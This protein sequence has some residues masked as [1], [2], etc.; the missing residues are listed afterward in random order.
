MVGHIHSES[1]L[2][3][4]A[5]KMIQVLL[6]TLQLVLNALAV[7]GV[8]NQRQHGPNAIHKQSTLARLR[9]IEGSLIII[10]VSNGAHDRKMMSA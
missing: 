8:A 9:V 3:V 10:N 5:T 7:R 1:L 6:L 2:A 4:E